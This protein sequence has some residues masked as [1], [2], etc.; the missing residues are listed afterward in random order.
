MR[1][2]HATPKA[3]LDSILE[4]GLDPARSQGKRKAIYLH[5]ASRREWAILHTIRRH[6]IGIDDVVI[7]SVDIPRSRITR[8]WRGLWSTE[9]KITVTE[10]N[11]TE[12]SELAESPIGK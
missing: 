9:T 3:N 8:R 12:A 2:Y 7:I 1:L 10:A 11:I 6:G 4:H 5:T